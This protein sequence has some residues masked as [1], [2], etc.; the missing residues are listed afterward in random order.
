MSTDTVLFGLFLTV[1]CF[2][3]AQ[4]V[5][6]RSKNVLANPII[7][8]VTMIIIVLLLFNIPLENF[9]K[10]ADLITIFLAPAT[11]A[12]SINIYKQRKL[13]MENLLPVL[14]GT[15]VGSL[16]AVLSTKYLSR[17]FGLSE[18]LMLSLLP[19]S[20]TTAIAAPL[21]ESYHGEVSITIL[22]VML[23]GIIGVVLGPV[24]IKL[25]RVN[26]VEAGLGMGTAS[27]VL[28]T[29]KAVELGEVEAAMSGLAIALA[30]IFT[31]IWMAL[32]L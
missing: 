19:K 8:S 4:M 1:L 11:A 9:R 13:L 23:A 31:I 10:G 24:I 25:L 22:A 20:T 26:P 12:L 3:L 7:L 29:T 16:T 6:K 27:H 18:K 14:G 32:L 30:G 5:Q 28:G 17:L 21:S 2:G 15:M